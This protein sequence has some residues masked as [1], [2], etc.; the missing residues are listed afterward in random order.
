MQTRVLLNATFVGS[1]GKLVGPDE[2]GA[3]GVVTD[4]FGE[5]AQPA[6]QDGVANHQPRL[7]VAFVRAECAHTAMAAQ[8]GRERERED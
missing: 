3:D 2:L 4:V 5:L 7:R 1:L 8:I 6:V